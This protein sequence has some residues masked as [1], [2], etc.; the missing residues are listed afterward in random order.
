MGSPLKPF[1]LGLQS[2]L[3]TDV[4]YVEETRIGLREI[5]LDIG[6]IDVTATRPAVSFPWCGIDFSE[7]QYTQKQFKVQW[8]K[9]R[10]SLRLAFDSWSSTSSLTPDNVKQLGLAFLDTE[11]KIYLS[12]QDWMV[13]YEQGKFLLMIGLRRISAV[14]ELRE[15][16]LRV[17]KLE[18]ECTFE[19]RGLQS[20]Q[21]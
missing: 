6:Q 21:M 1:F 17:R 16:T 4:P 19:D 9:V 13:E 11:D 3:K 20:A 10:V 5:N 7:I 12:L 15:D 8:A 14:T 2:K 18:F